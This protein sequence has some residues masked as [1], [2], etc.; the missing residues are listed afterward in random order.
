MDMSDKDEFA[1]KKKDS[2]NTP[3]DWRISVT[4][5]TILYPPENPISQMMDPFRQNLWHDD[6]FNVH[7]DAATSSSFRDS[8]FIERAAKFSFLECGSISEMMMNQQSLGVPESVGLFLQDSQIESGSKLS[9]KGPVKDRSN[10]LSHVSVDSQSSGGNG[11]DDAKCW[12]KSS[13]G[14]NSKKRKRIGKD[15]E[16][17]QSLRTQQSGEEE[18]EE[19]KQKDEQSPKGGYIH[20]RARKGQATN[21]HS[22]AERVRREKISERMKFLQDLVPG[23]D[24]VTGKAVMLDE[25]INYVQSLQCQI[26]FLSMKLSTVNPTLDSNLESLLPKDAL[27]VSAPTFPQNMSMLYPPLSYLSQTGFIQPNISS[28][29]PLNGQLKRQETHGYEND[30]HNV[31]HMNHET[32]TAPD[33]EDT[34]CEMDI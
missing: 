27:Q 9:G 11:D 14:F 33:H 20:I 30:H 15:S 3:V 34:K 18:E 24:K 4:N 31:V 1:S 22:L 13:K 6:G 7:T 5:P 26:E 2:V 28:V 32:G 12:E 29:S 23:C 19:K 21:S 17:D 8:G 16:P 25:I 10:E